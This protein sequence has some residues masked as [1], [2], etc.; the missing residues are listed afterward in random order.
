LVAEYQGEAE[1]GWSRYRCESEHENAFKIR[2]MQADTL[3]A[4]HSRLSDGAYR[5]P[6]NF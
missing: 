5:L 4:D 6:T 2:K 1:D 3:A